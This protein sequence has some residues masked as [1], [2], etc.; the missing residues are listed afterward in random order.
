MLHCI[1]F[2]HFVYL[3]HGDGPLSVPVMLIGSEFGVSPDLNRQIP[4]LW[5]NNSSEYKKG[6]LF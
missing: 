3:F 6:L 1:D 4:D 2:Q 5:I